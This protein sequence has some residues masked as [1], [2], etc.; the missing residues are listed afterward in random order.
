MVDFLRKESEACT[1]WTKMQMMK[2]L[3]MHTLLNDVILIIKLEEQWIIIQ[4]IWK[5]K[6]YIT[7]S[8]FQILQNVL[9]P[10]HLWEIRS[11]V[12]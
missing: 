1:Q 8:L 9:M 3:H 11:S 12:V 7:T 10:E 5:E 6:H 2:P 4:H